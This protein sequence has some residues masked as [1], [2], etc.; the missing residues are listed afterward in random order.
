MLSIRHVVNADNMIKYLL[1]I[2]LILIAEPIILILAAVNMDTG[3]VINTA[4]TTL[5]LIVVSWISYKV[6]KLN[7]KADK[8]DVKVEEYH[9][10]VNGKMGQLLEVTEKAGKAEGNIE[11]RKENQAETDAKEQKDPMK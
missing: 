2:K 5:G 8:L 1:S 7:V 11:G 9:K 4:I 3:T 6:A 10:E